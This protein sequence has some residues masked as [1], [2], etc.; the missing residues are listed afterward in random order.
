MHHK[1]KGSRLRLYDTKDPVIRK[2]VMV[3]D[4]TELLL[5]VNQLA[6]VC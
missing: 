4:R 3:K 6:L 2:E 1:T 5:A